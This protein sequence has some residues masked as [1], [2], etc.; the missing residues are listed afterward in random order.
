M[1]VLVAGLMAVAPALLWGQ[2]DGVV[3]RPMAWQAAGGRSVELNLAGPAGGPIADVWFSQDGTGLL[4]RTDRGFVWSTPDSGETWRRVEAAAD[5]RRDGA[6]AEAGTPPRGEPSARIYRHA[7]NSRY[8]FALGEHLYRSSDEGRTWVNLTA[9]PLGSI[10]GGGQRAIAFSPADRDSVVVAN[11]YGL[12]RSADGG[13]S[14]TGLNRNLPNLPESRLL[15]GTAGAARPVLRGIGAVAA[16]PEG[17]WQPARDTVAASLPAEDQRRSSPWLMDLPAGWAASYR[18][19]RA[20]SPATGDLTFCADGPCAEPER[21]YISAFSLQR[22]ASSGQTPARFYAGTSDGHLWISADGGSTWQPPRQGFGAAGNPIRSLWVDP[23]NPF[24]ALAAVGS[25]R[26]GRVFRT[27][28]GG[29]FWDDLTANLPDGA[30]HAVEANPETG[31]IYVATEAG[32][33]YTRADLR[34]P[35]PATPWTRLAGNLPAAPIDDLRLDT[36][37]GTL[38]VAVAGYGLYHAAVPDIADALRVLNA[39]DLSARA[40]APGGLLTVVGASVRTARAGSWNAPVLAAGDTES[41]IQVPFEATG[42]TLSLALDTQR[43]LRRVGIPLDAVSPAIFVDT[44]GSPLVLDASGVLLHPSR[45]AHAGSRIVIL[46]TG[47][48]QVRPDWPTGMA[49]PLEDPPPVT[50]TPVEVHLSGAPLRV[51]SST[52]AGGYIGVYTVTAELP[53]ILNAGSGELVIGAGGKTSNRVRIS[54]EP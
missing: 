49:A 25:R 26:T 35:G 15:A 48:G 39:A 28:N 20:G 10:I 1:R 31:S 18:L 19:W 23:G 43:G 53:A 24:V 21:H 41:Q 50:V 12:W 4:V 7:Y 33:F 52:L 42:P 51:V 27:T 47:L 13:L 16:G 22:G 3:E 32:V 54:L 29:L 9:D 38:S 2:D 44:D 37:T 34:N 5:A 46:A 45:S 6:G 40:A 8:L 17:V 36:L 14:W 30:A 11:A